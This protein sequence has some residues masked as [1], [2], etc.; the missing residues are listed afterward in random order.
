MP[1]TTLIDCDELDRRLAA[2]RGPRDLRLVDCRFDLADPQGG[3]RA[4]AAGHLPGA[5]YADL[6][7]DLSGPKNGRNGRHPLPSPD[8]LIARLRAWGIDDTTQ[9]VAYD[10]QGGSFAA[11]LWWLLRRL[12]HEA[13]A[14]LDGGVP[15]WT[16]SGRPLETATPHVAAGQIAAAPP[17][18][19][20]IGARDV[21]AGI[22]AGVQAAAAHLLLDARAPERFTG[23]V[24]PIDPVGGHIPGARNRF[25]QSNLDAGRFKSPAT[26]RSE[27]LALLDGR[28]ATEVVGYCG[29][30][31]TACHNLL[32]LHL[33]GLPGATLYPGSWSE[34]VADRQRPVA[35][36]SET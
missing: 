36:G 13:V 6:E 11:R 15:A 34:W 25:W 20:V 10:A 9:V 32:A 18:E 22:Q 2:G 28:A 31:V 8:D 23:A 21:Q 12:G 3:A 5:V 26:L 33:A 35:R 19:T 24:E 27:Y 17:L 30:G 14:V 29:S 1:L 7:R 4:Y 16:A